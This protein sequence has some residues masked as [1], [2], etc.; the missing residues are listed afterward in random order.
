MATPSTTLPQIDEMVREYLVFRG[1]LH[2]LRVFDSER[3]HDRTKSYQGDKIVEQLFTYIHNFDLRNLMDLWRYLETRFFSRLDAKLYVAV[4]KLEQ[5]LKRYYLVFCIQNAHLDHVK[6]FFETS[7][8]ELARDEE[9]K[10]WFVLPF[11]KN[12]EQHPD[13]EPYFSKQWVEMLS[14]SLQNFISTMIVSVPKPMIFSLEDTQREK[15][16]L[17]KKVD[18]LQLEV[19]NL[20]SK[21]S[22]QEQELQS[23]RARTTQVRPLSLQQH[24][25]RSN[26]SGAVNTIPATMMSSP[27][28]PNTSSKSTSS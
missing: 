23:S 19:D 20:R 26:S 14:I 3:K 7:A 15:N 13:F 22:S 24:P 12:P 1:F 16:V 28:Q 9:W 6:E 10:P 4:R 21:L 17:L 5:S 8:E 18:A 27:Q 25:P 11:M 2:C